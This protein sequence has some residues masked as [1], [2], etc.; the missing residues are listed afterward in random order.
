MWIP[1]SEDELL[2]AMKAGEL[3]ETAILDVKRALPM[4]GKSKD[5]AIDVAAMANDGGTLI[6]GVGEDQHKRPPPDVESALDADS[7]F[8]YT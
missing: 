5:L 8:S 6:Y 1:N 2:R 7:L 3:T 4:K